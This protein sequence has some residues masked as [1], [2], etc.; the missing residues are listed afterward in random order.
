MGANLWQAASL[1]ARRSGDRPRLLRELDR[2]AALGLTNVRIMG[3]IEGFAAAPSA[4]PLSA[5]ERAQQ[6]WPKLECASWC[7]AADGHC[8]F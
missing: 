3:A 6:Q 4:P 2:L 1:G 8:D 7:N 5:E